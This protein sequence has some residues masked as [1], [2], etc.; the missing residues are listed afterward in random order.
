M[1]DI[2]K[3]DASTKYQNATHYSTANR[4]NTN[5]PAEFQRKIKKSDTRNSAENSFL[6]FREK[7]LEEREAELLEMLK[8]A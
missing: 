4:Q 5:A 8:D 3:A 7:E 2:E 1:K 6:K